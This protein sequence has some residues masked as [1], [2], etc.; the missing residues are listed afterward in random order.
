[1]KRPDG[2]FFVVPRALLTM[3]LST[4]AFATAVA[5]CSCADKNGECFPSRRVLAGIA[6]V[7]RSTVTVL[8]QELEVH[9]VVQVDRRRAQRA[10]SKYK[11]AKWLWEG[12]EVPGWSSRTTTEADGERQVDAGVVVV[13]DGVVVRG[14]GVVVQGDTELDSRTRFKE[15]DGDGGAGGSENAPPAPPPIEFDGIQFTHIESHLD[16][17]EARY[18][19]VDL[20]G[21]IAA[22]EEYW[23]RPDVADTRELRWPQRYL[24]RRFANRLAELEGAAVDEDRIPY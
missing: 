10:T 9:G 6:H 4:G 16:A 20:F 7:H 17:W 8:V 13:D 23:T 3:G 14:E 15:L 19:G 11:I 21:E 2:T 1:V 22:A 5:I 12:S 24:E 18:P